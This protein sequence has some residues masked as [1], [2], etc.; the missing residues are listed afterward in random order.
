MRPSRAS[1]LV[2]VLLAAIAWSC[3]G[4]VWG[5]APEVTELKQD[6]PLVFRDEFNGNA[7]DK[8]VWSTCYAW[9]KSDEVGCNNPSH[10]ELEWYLPANVVVGGGHVQ[11]VA[12][13][14]QVRGHPYT[15]GMISSQPGFSFTYGYAEMRVRMPAGAGLWPAFWLVPANGDWPPEIDVVELLGQDVRTAYMN[16]YVPHGKGYWDSLRSYKGTDLSRGFHTFGVLW[17]PDQIVW[18]ID[19]VV[20]SEYQG[21]V[22]DVPMVIIANLAIGGEWAGPPDGTTRFPA[23]MVID[24][25]RVWQAAPGPGQR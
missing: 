10:T 19:G 17:E 6:W 13:E 20:R 5:A 9:A 4:C 23:R 12:R 21:S 1:W 25:I 11:F 15:S 16:V 18:Y 14:Q 22:S 7:L 8:N 24:Y 3:A 2:P